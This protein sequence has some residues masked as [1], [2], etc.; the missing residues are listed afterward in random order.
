[1][2]HDEFEQWWGRL[3]E[4]KLELID[5]KLI[6]GNSLSG[7]QLLFRMILEGWGAA[8]VVALVD[9]KLCWEAL[10][11]A[12]PDAPISTSEKGEHT[13]AE[14]WAS[15]FDYQPE[16]LS[17][18]EYGKDEG[19][20]TTRDS[21]E[22]QLSKATSIGGCGQSIGPDFVMHLGNSGIT[23]D[24]LLSRG[25]P[26]NHIYNWYM[27]GPADLV[28]EVILPAHAAQDR[29]V[30]RHYYE[31]GGVPEYWIVD[32]Q[33][34]QID[35]LR[36]A[37]GQYWP[38]RPDSEGRYRP[39]NIP[40]LV[41]LP[42]NLWLP[43]SQ[44]NRFCLSIFEV[45]AQTQ[46]KVKAAF[47]EEGG[48]KPDSLAFVPRVALDSVSIS[49]EEFVSWCP[50]AKIEY[51]NN[52]IQIVGMRQF[53]GLLLMTLGMVETVKLLP[54]QQ[55]ISAL[56][57]AEVNEFN[58]AARKARW[59]KIAKQSAALLRK[60]HGA[61]RLAVIGD[62]VRPLPLNYWSDITLVVYDLSREARW[63]GGQALNEMFKNPRLYLVEPK[64][65]DE[66]LANNE[67]VEI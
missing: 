7:S 45:R 39:H 15:Q 50:R 19:H 52:K 13:Q 35:F 37:G 66:S 21:L 55:W 33:R 58:D 8:A 46:K 25:N 67:L 16:D 56:I 14:A 43:Q 49:F 64:Y 4:S 54:P 36:F 9:R 62:L 48:F 29:E 17:A 30:K 32:P 63:E 34:Q 38:V 65:A 5:G 23:P 20:R 40:N 24:I 57:E 42:D 10:K 44:T 12:Y 11:V 61:T 47:D 59:W 53:L 26:L 41:F 28:I 31:A 18:G 1:M 60:K 2:T 3:P 27:E 22:V 51:A 6:V